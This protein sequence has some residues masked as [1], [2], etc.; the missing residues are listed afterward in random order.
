MVENHL[1][2]DDSVEQEWQALDQRVGNWQAQLNDLANNQLDSD[3]SYTLRDQAVADL[4]KHWRHYQSECVYS[5]WGIS[6]T[7]QANGQVKE[8]KDQFSGLATSLGFAISRFGQPDNYQW[9]LGYIFRSFNHRQPQAYPKSV[10]F[11][12]AASADISVIGQADDIF[13]IEPEQLPKPCFDKAL[14]EQSDTLAETMN[15]SE[16]LKLS[17]IDQ[18]DLLTTIL[19][20][21]AKTA[22]RYGG[23]D[24]RPVKIRAEKG[25]LPISST[26]S[27]DIGFIEVD[28]T[29]IAVNGH[30]RGLDILGFERLERLKQPIRDCS[31]WQDKPAGLYL[32]IDIDQPTRVAIGLDYQ[33]V[34]LPLSGQNL[35]LNFPNRFD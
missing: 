11:I 26:P 9:R 1:P 16:F 3:T 15:D 25:Y 34:Y 29:N 10:V 18:Y 30:C 22:E 12:D 33:L 13:T 5:G 27:N 7:R 4:N 28:L 20:Q 19:L 6:I 14:C 31:D 23:L 17:A 21:T 32:A 8:T 2:V 35:A 24:D